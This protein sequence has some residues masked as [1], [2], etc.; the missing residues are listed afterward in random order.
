MSNTHSDYI[1]D[2]SGKIVAFLD[3]IPDK[4]EHEFNGETLHF[5]DEGEYFTES[6]M[7]EHALNDG[8]DLHEFF[9]LHGI[10]G[11]TCSCSKCGKPFQPDF[12][13]WP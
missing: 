1:T 11:A 7:P 8:R 9:I 6:E 12:F 5:N 4:C 3:G 13:G 2:E 10:R